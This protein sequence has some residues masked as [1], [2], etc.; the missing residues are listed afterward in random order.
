MDE[1]LSQKLKESTSTAHQELEK[2]V[3]QKIKSIQ[4][5]EDYLILLGYFYRFFAPLEKEIVSQ[6]ETALPDMMRRRKTEWILDDLDYFQ[7]TP[8]PPYSSVLTIDHPSQAIGALYVIE[9]STLGGQIICKMIAERLGIS[10]EGGFK[11][12]S[13]YGDDTNKMWL[14]F[15]FFLDHHTW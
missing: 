8:L 3:V 9:G 1:M 6:L 5:T 14:D 12:F 10:A 13:G 15:K 4:D 7:A 11:F 2:L